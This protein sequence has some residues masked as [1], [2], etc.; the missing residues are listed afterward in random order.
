MCTR[1]VGWLLNVE[2]AFIDYVSTPFLLNQA[3]HAV[4]CWHLGALNQLLLCHLEFIVLFLFV[5]PL[6][7]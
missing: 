6:F 1:I 2:K 7:E 3:Y 4:I 5:H